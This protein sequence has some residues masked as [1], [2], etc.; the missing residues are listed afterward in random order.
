MKKLLVIALLCLFVSVLSLAQGLKLV[1]NVGGYDIE[2]FIDSVDNITGEFS[3]KYRY[4]SQKNYLEIDGRNFDD[5]IYIE[6]YYGENMTGTF[7]LEMQSETLTGVWVNGDNTKSF[8]VELWAEDE[9]FNYINVK[10]LIEYNAECSDKISGEYRTEYYFIN[11]Y[12]VTEDN[13]VYELGFNGGSATFEELEDG[14]LKFEIELI[15]GPT[16]HFAIAE[17]IAV[18]QGDVY[19]Y[20]ANEWETEENCEITFKF[21]NKKV[22]ASSSANYECGFGARAYM[23]HSLMKVGE[24]EEQ[25]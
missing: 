17:G 1:G 24:L 21:E 4:L 20:S 10:S 7:Y 23:D 22:Y 15:C 6:E 18:K 14:S 8:D 2:M 25:E 19:I 5:V 3:G 11:D 16:Y 13:P 9:N 12:F